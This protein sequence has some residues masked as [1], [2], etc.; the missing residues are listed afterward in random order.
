ML[1]HFILWVAITIFNIVPLQTSQIKEEHE[2]KNLAA[3]QEISPERREE[4]SRKLLSAIPCC[5]VS[6]HESESKKVIKTIDGLI[7]EGADVNYVGKP[8]HEPK[9][10]L[11]MA[12]EI[13]FEDLVQL[14]LQAGANP[15]PAR[16]GEENAL[17]IVENLE[18]KGTEYLK[19][20][21]TKY[22][23]YF[24]PEFIDEAKKKLASYRKIVNLV[25]KAEQDCQTKIEM[26]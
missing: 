5:Y 11:E 13:G 19:K 22:V 6:D 8:P 23:E 24:L 4:L 1:F 25:K 16:K 26:S 3:Q 18:H 21:S 2:Q 15:L 9:T 20:M 12:I 7:K 17:S 14:L 10:P